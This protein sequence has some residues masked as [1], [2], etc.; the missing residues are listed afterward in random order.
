MANERDRTREFATWRGSLS[1]RISRRGEGP[2]LGC[3]YTEPLRSPPCSRCQYPLLDCFVEQF[4]QLRCQKMRGVRLLQEFRTVLSPFFRTASFE[5]P[6]IN[7]TF[8]CGQ[9]SAIASAN[10]GPLMLGMTTSLMS[11]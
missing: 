10:R 11:A 2:M 7:R 1:A 4:S 3:N 6:E 8:N 5:C 9:N